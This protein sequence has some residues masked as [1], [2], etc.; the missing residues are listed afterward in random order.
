MPASAQ[1]RFAMRKLHAC[2][3]AVRDRGT[4]PEV[5]GLLAA[6]ADMLARGAAGLGLP[7]PARALDSVEEALALARVGLDAALVVDALLAALEGREDAALARLARAERR[8]AREAALPDAARGAIGR[9][10]AAG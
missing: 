1:L 3:R 6:A 10:L 2:V 7:D 4:G 8:A 9:V 5:V